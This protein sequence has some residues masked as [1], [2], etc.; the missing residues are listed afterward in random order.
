MSPGSKIAYRFGDF[1]LVPRDKQLL[2]DGMPVGLTPKVFDALLLLVESRGHLVEKQE[3]M[4][5]LWPES[6]VQ[7]DSLA[8]AISPSFARVSVMGMRI[9]N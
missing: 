7:E 3:L 1:V 2:R 4:N 9:W 5:R 6:F 8:Q